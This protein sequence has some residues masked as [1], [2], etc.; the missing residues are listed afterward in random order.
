[1]AGLSFDLKDLL[2]GLSETETKMELAVGMLC[3]TEAKNL[4]K[5]AKEQAR[6]TDRTGAARQR[7]QGYTHRTTTGWRIVLAHGVDYGIWLELANEK[8]FAIVGPLI[9][10]SAPYILRDFENLMDKIKL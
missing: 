2:Q 6:W 3:E 5:D 10:L 1:M 9:Q 4:E 7:L 8:R